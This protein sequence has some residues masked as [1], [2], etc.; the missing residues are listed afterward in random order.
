MKRYLKA[1]I[2]ETEYTCHCECSHGTLPSFDD[3]GDPPEIEIL[4]VTCDDADVTKKL[5]DSDYQELYDYL[6]ENWV[7]DDE[8]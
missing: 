5:T 7:D 6:Y 2:D 1:K 3:P 8:R 4:S